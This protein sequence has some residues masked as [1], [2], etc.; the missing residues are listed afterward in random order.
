MKNI[1]TLNLKCL[2]MPLSQIFKIS[3]TLAMIAWLLLII[4]PRWKW[5]GRIIIGFIIT[6]LCIVYIYMLVGSFEI[7]DFA[8]FGNLTGVMQLFTNERV[9][10]AG[11]VHYLAFDLMVGLFIVQNSVK[12]DISHILI[13]LCLLLTFMLGP[14]GLFLYLLIRMMITKRYFISYP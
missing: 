4:A 9:V 6:L 10:L 14:V 3:N 13:I 7:D 2:Y 12:N 5:T 11:W 1:F 8:S